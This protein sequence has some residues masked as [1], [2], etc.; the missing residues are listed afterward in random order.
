MVIKRSLGLRGHSRLV[1]PKYS[2]GV[3]SDL[4]NGSFWI[5]IRDTKG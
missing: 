5:E 3:N 4:G 1:C 2:A